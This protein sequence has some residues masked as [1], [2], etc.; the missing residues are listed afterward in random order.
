MMV[1]GCPMVGMMVH[2]FPMVGM[3]VHGFPMVHVSYVSLLPGL[4]EATL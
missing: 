3:M 4:I 1:H 2:G